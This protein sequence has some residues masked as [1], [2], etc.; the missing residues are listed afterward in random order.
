MDSSVKLPRD[1]LTEASLQR[2]LER[3]NQDVELMDR[4]RDLSLRVLLDTTEDRFLI[5]LNDRRLSFLGEP[6]IDDSWDLAIRASANSWRK[7]LSPV[8]PPGYQS[9]M[10]LRT[11]DPKFSMDGNQL[12]AAQALPVLERLVHV[13]RQLDKN[14]SAHKA[15]PEDQQPQSAFARNPNQIC[16]RYIDLPD[17]EGKPW[18]IY[19]EEAGSGTPLVL[20]HTA[21][22]DS[23]QFHD[24]LCDVEIG[25]CWRML[26]FD[27]PYH[28]RSTPAHGWW[29]T[30][31][32]LSTEVYAHWCV[33]FIREVARTRAV[34]MGGSMGAAMAVY[35]A[36]RH[37]A[38]VSAAI[39]VEAPDRSTPRLNRFLTNPQVNQ[40]C[41]IPTYVYGLMSPLSPEEQRRRAWWFYSQGGYGVYEGDLSFYS[42]EWDANTLISEFDVSDCPVYLL[43]GE[44]DYSASPESTLRLAGLIPGAH[45][46][47]MQGLGHF[48]MTEDPDTFRAYL[49][50]ILA[51]LK[52]VLTKP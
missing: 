35:M 41:Y 3:A 45:V 39:G 6:R 23:R 25:A 21:G 48:P 49:L 4:A 31:Y 19:Y 17:P 37:R 1:L 22:A 16:G 27:L 40:A 24:L 42:E 43:T 14:K 30:P 7:L 50:P 11:T 34:V 15:F 12:L 51:E 47:I 36:A 32:R 20:L 46:R 8:P 9:F 44:Y 26:A 29:R 13:A 38:D 10:A 2:L 33:T 52:R 5:V 28:G 18:R